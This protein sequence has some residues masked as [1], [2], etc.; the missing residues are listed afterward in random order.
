MWVGTI[1]L[2]EDPKI[3]N[4]KVKGG[5]IPNFSLDELE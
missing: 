5:Q 3:K 4:K 2:T 1:Q